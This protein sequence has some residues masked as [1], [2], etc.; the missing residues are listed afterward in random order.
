MVSIATILIA[1]IPCLVFSAGI[2]LGCWIQR[3]ASTPKL[4]KPISYSDKAMA[5][6]DR[7]LQD[8]QAQAMMQ[9]Y[10]KGVQIDRDTYVGT[11]GRMKPMVPEDMK[12]GA[13]DE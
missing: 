9:S 4:L 11:S 8:A 6:K 2:L 1:L 13:R 5:L 10:L 7:A 3:K 12:D